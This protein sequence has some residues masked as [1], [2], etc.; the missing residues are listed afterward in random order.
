[1]DNFDISED[2]W[3]LL[4]GDRTAHVHKSC[5]AAEVRPVSSEVSHFEMNVQETYQ[6]KQTVTNKTY[7]KAQLAEENPDH[8]VRFVML[9][10]DSDVMKVFQFI[11]QFFETSH[12]NFKII[13]GAYS[14]VGFVFDETHFAQF[15]VQIFSHGKDAG[16]C[17]HVL[18]GTAQDA[19]SEFW[20]KLQNALLES[21]F[22]DQMHNEL[23]LT[24]SD[25]EFFMDWEEEDQ[26]FV[27]PMPNLR[28]SEPNVMQ[29]THVTS[30]ME[31][32]QD[33]SFMLHALLLL[34][35]NCQ[36]QQ[37][38]EV[39]SSAG[40]AQ[41]LFDLII[42]CLV[43]TATDFC[44]PI[45]RSA[46]LLVSKLAETGDVQISEQ[47]FQVLVNTIVQW[48]IQNNNGDFAETVTQ[49]EEIAQLLSSKLPKFAQDF[50]NSECLQQLQEVYCRVPFQ[51]VRQNIKL[52]VE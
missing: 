19:V 5:R 32:M 45:A 31:E 50:S 39:I 16:V 4:F 42:A 51:S 41:Q 7:C 8:L 37:N 35:W 1:M 43:A 38:I 33:Q 27:L 52:L 18:D 47:Q 34:S 21:D 30:L 14:I 29:P 25:E 22:V 12:K 49:S 24:E 23:E 40:Q 46:S 13:E 3:D 28:S 48:T 2:E 15:R 11:I 20:S 36:L 17:V 9:A 44:L 26:D 6:K 10:A